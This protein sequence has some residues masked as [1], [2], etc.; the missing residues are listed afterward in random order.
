MEMNL[1][2]IIIAIVVMLVIGFVV[3]KS[4]TSKIK[5]N[6]DGLEIDSSKKSEVKVSDISKSDVDITSHNDRGITVEK[7]KDDSKVTVK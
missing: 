6:P 5:L 3:Y 1:E 2:N 4:S 7:V